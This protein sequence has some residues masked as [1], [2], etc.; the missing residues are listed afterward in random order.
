MKDLQEFCKNTSREEVT[1]KLKEY[2]V[3]FISKD[4]YIYIYILYDLFIRKE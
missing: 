3:K 2:D 1:S 4:I